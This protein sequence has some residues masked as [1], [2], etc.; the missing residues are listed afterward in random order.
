MDSK[1]SQPEL[2]EEGEEGWESKIM[3]RE[4]ERDL[5]GQERSWMASLREEGP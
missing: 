4:W 5:K 1:F 3:E 2:E